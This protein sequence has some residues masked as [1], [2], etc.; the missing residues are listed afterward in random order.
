MAEINRLRGADWILLALAV[1]VAGGV[2][3]WYVLTTIP[4]GSGPVAL[5][6]QTRIPS[7]PADKDQRVESREDFDLLVRNLQGERWFGAQAPLADSPE[8]TAHVS[9]AYFW[10]TAW[11]SHF[12]PSPDMVLRW[13]QIFLG[14]WTVLCYFFFARRAFQSTVAAGI[15]GLLM[16]L[17][18]FWIIN[19][20]ELADGVLASFLLGATLVLG[21]RASQVGGAFTSLLFGLSLAA[22]SMTRAALLPFSLVAL[23]WFLFRCRSI[24]LGWFCGLLTFLGFA[25]GLAPWMVRNFQ[26]FA[27]PVPIVTST[28]LHL[29]MGNNDLASGGPQDEKTLRTS[30]GPEQLQALLAESNQARRYARLGALAVEQAAADPG[31]TLGRRINS[32]LY[33]LFGEAWFTKKQLAERAES[34]GDAPP[35]VLANADALLRGSLLTLL[36][37]AILGWRFSSGWR[38]QSRLAALAAVWIPLPYLLGHADLL[39]GPR[40]PLDGLLLCFAAFAIACLFPGTTRC[41]GKKIASPRVN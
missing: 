13:L 17:Y 37:L 23:V 2:R 38:R 28:Y 33:F 36:L 3:S 22:L 18:P 41:P 39:S 16:A 10:L 32:G 35:W 31:A 11:I 5:A 12:E 27:E 26:A 30:L 20:G 34:G 14:T 21:T 4:R 9:P 25:N 8:T 1:L 19:T 40:L 6:V 7:S 24:K 15:T 29:Y